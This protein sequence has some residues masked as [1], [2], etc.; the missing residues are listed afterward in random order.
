[1]SSAVDTP[2]LAYSALERRATLATV[3]VLLVLAGL[4]W[5]RTVGNAD[6]MG[7]MVQG[8]AW[9]GTAM[10]FD[11]SVGV[12]LGMWVTMMV[13]MMFPAIAPIVLLHRMVIRKQGRG[14]APTVA[15]AGGYLAVWSVSGLVP[16]A[17]LLG[18]R[19]A[20]GGSRWVELAAGVVL[21]AAGGYQF[22]SWKQT[23]LRACRTPLTFLA[24]HDFGRGLRGTF[25]AGLSHGL[26]CL[27]C[28]WALM[29]VL[30]VVGL[31]NLIWMAAIAI[32]FLAEKNWSRGVGL[33]KVVGTAVVVLG[34]AILV[35]P[36]LLNSLSPTPATSSQMSRM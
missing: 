14:L 1:M 17:L 30:L 10:P 18:F 4:A 7:S 21:V 2:R 16:L 22:T 29:A 6:D 36:S 15:F 19:H 11:M 35:H 28:C 31:M 33:T 26:Y 34:V 24:T 5:W 20:A 3:A 23:C 9:V 25:R 32:V 8:F 13:A 27:G 12:F